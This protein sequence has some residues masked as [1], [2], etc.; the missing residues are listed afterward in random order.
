MRRA[1]GVAWSFASALLA[2]LTGV[3]L[4]AFP[5]GGVFTL[6]AIVAGFLILDGL[7]SIQLALAYRR[8]R[9]GRWGWLLASAVVDLALAAVILTGLP[10]SAGWAL[11]LIVGLNL[12]F[13]GAALVVMALHA[14]DAATVLRWP[15]IPSKP[16]DVTF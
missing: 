5:L 3:A 2:L 4:L 11:G 8:Q 1:S 6:T 10:V 9:I 13:G 7:F 12:A 16:A 15:L 14:R